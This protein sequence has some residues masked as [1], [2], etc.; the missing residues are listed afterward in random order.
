MTKRDFVV[1]PIRFC[2]HERWNGVSEV[3]HILMC[4]DRQEVQRKTKR[5]RNF[6]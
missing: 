4:G 2:Y 3:G 5:D 6:I 1:T